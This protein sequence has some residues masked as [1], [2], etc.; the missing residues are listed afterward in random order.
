MAVGGRRARVVEGPAVEDLEE[1]GGDL[2]VVEVADGEEQQEE[3][4]SKG[5][6]VLLA[7]EEMQGAAVEQPHCQHT[8]CVHT[9][10]LPSGLSQFF[11]T[12]KAMGT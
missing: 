5:Q 2:C 12:A 1:G 8:H 9:Q 10:P 6:A 11:L 7:E 4:W 3:L